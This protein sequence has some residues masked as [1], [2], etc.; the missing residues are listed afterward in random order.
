M[1]GP[2]D[3]RRLNAPQ[4]GGAGDDTATTTMGMA[5]L[6]I[7]GVLPDGGNE[8]VTLGATADVFTLKTTSAEVDGLEVSEGGLSRLR[9]GLK[10]ARPFP[11]QT[12]L[13]PL[14]HGDGHPARQWGC[15]IRLWSGSGAGILW[16]AP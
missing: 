7:D 3:H 9:L 12:V 1:A 13:L 2:L 16:N 11:F 4:S 6:G 5:A 15:R 10:P 8:G 14:F